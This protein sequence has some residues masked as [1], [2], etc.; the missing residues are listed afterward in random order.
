MLRLFGRALLWALIGS[1][2]TPVIGCSG[3][4]IIVYATDPRCGTPGDSG[5]CEMGV[6]VATI[7]LILIGAILFVSGVLLQA[8]W[9]NRRSLRENALRFWAQCR[10]WPD[11]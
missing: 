5:G 7:S 10:R 1:V 8:A 11:T 4:L 2:V 6:G 3:L 9:Q